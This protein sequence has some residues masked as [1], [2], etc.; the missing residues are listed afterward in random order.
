[1][2]RVSTNESPPTAVESLDLRTLFLD[3]YGSIWRLLRRLGVRES[4]LDDA[5]QEVFWVAARRLSDIRPGC[6]HTFLYGVALRVA[7]GM[8]RSSVRSSRALTSLD[9]VSAPTCPRPDPEQRLEN[10]QAR[11]VLDHVL[12]QMSP[13]L[14]SVFVLFELEDVPIKDI[15]EIHEIPVGTV[16]SRL[17]RARAEFSEVCKRVQAIARRE[18]R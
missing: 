16:S 4:E 2:Q 8:R 11:E 7:S 3:H 14:R 9:E 12:D 10:R 13:A 18:D 1:M 5:A 15:A 6:G 17:R